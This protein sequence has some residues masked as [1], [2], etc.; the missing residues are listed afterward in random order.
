MKLYWS[1]AS[2]YARKVRMVIAERRLGDLVEEVTVATT[3]DPPELTAANPLGKIPALV[4]DEGFS[5]F[6]SPVICA[7]L[8]AH[9]KAEG[10]RLRPHTGDARW[11]VMRAEA[12]GDGLMDLG[13]NLMGDRRKP[14]GERSPT[15]VKRWHSQLFRSLD[16]APEMLR[17]LPEQITLG[18][19]A[20]IC[21][22]GYLDF[23]HDELQWRIGRDE[24]ANWFEKMSAVPSVAATKPVA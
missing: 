20:V 2:P 24:L 13:L 10:E 8:D 5:L 1:P 19:F 9:P 15:A 23:R 12:F 17:P 21:G 4:T 22:L 6:D 16:A 14:D 3:E 11:L 7:Y 18:H